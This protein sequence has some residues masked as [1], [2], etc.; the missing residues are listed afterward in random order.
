MARAGQ[1]SNMKVSTMPSSWRA[2]G[3]GMTVLAG[4]ALVLFAGSRFDAPALL[5]R[6]GRPSVA[7]RAHQAQA[8][9]A[10]QNAD[11]A[12][13]ALIGT[14][15]LGCHNQRLKSGGL[16][17][18]GIDPGRVETAPD[19][20][21]KV[22]RKLRAGAMPPAGRPRP[23]PAATAAFVSGLEV[24]LDRAALANPD[25]GR[26]VVHRLN[27]TEYTNAVRDLLALEI[28]GRAML[29]ADDTDKH[30]FDNNADVLSISPAL[31]ERY[32]SAARK[33]SRM[34]IG[35]SAEPVITAYTVPKMLQQDERLGDDLPFGSRGG[36]AIHHYFPVDG[37]YRVKI[38]LQ[39]N[40][41]DIIRGLG[42]PHTLELR[43]DGARVQSFV[44]GGE[45]HGEPGP[46]A[47][48]GTIDGSPDWEKYAREADAKF[49]VRFQ[50]ESGTPAGHGGVRERSLAVR[51]HDPAA[52]GWIR[53]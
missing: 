13:R 49:E 36:T 14:Y 18:E 3:R 2:S 41:Y 30:G 28:D 20:W 47:F 23:A 40:L 37:E 24:A 53:A 7:A 6:E 21:E 10:V 16:L 38:R 4:F 52:P 42:A 27:R 44:V 35:T 51:R 26:P 12:G 17:L 11:A 8:P 22:I 25:P 31:L 15:C 50:R 34:A 9:A 39:R 29:P 33:I 48:G 45:D 32:I 43:V 46:V 1:P 19:V 5:A